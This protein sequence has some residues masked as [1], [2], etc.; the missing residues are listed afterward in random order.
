MDEIVQRAM[1]RWPDVPAVYGWLG[2]DERGR[3][4]IKGEPVRNEATSAFIGRNYSC[5][6]RGR[7]YFQNGPQ[8]VFATL[9][10]TPWIVRI[11]SA[12]HGS[13]GPRFETHVGEPV[14]RVEAALLDETG[15]LILLLPQGPGRVLDRDL[16]RVA[17]HLRS[18]AG[19][20]VQESDLESALASAPGRPTGLVLELDRSRL[21]VERVQRADLAARFGFVACPVPPAGE[22]ECY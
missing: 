17:D 20:P 2:L 18:S 14:E 16:P 19:S 3:W 8:R 4:T 13:P 9:A 10:C 1:A 7:W 15:G 6:E 12:R 5:D 22:P 21:A 11:A